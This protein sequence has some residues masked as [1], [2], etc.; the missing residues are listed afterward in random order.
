[1][2]TEMTEWWQHGIVYQVYIRSFA[3]GNA[4]GQ[5]DLAGLRTRLDYLAE[6]GIDAVWI[7]PWYDSPMR[8]GGYDVA[9]YRK[10]APRFGTV[11]EATQFIAEAHERNIKV[12]ADLVPNHTSS[13]HAWFQEA[14]AA[15]P[16]SPA[17]DRYIFR[18]G[19]GPDGSEP[20]SNW[21]G[22]FG[23]PA[24]EQVADGEWYLHIFDTS[25][26]DL[27]WEHPEVRAEFE[28]IFRFWLDRGVDGFRIDVA[29]GLIKDLTFPDVERA[30]RILEADGFDTPEPIDHPFW[31]RDGVHEIIRTW[32]AIVDEYDD[33]MMVA[34]AWAHRKRLPLY[35]RPDEYHQSF[36]FDLLAAEWRAESFGSIISNSLDAANE[37]GATSTWVLSN[38]D[39]VRHATRYGL[40]DGVAW[41]E[42]IN[43]GPFDILDLELGTRRARAVALITLALPGSTYVYQ[44]EEL[45]LHEVWDLP[46]EVLDDPTWERSGHT[47]RGRDGT[48]VPI[49]WATNGPSF[50]FGDGDPWLPQPDWFGPVSAAAQ[51][52]DPSSMLALYRSAIALRSDHFATNRSLEMVDLGNDVL[53][54][55]RGNVL[56]VANMSS[57]PIALP[58]GSIVLA[59]G[60]LDGNTIPAD[61]SV[62]VEQS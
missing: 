33:R 60:E 31:D 26:P 32:R 40:P 43:T 52:D 46:D 15:G 7:N 21:Q 56:V 34:E 38:H 10:I 12:I 30:S 39:V 25:Q 55:T 61:T 4:D 57:E 42:W 58:E 50:G 24:W 2:S 3:D 5:G 35:L 17:R 1:M 54:F 8:D 59:S 28:D 18:P 22:V 9:D 44:G 11:D 47:A 29:H 45:G 62:W 14:L 19:K 49:P 36:N 23:G 20:P 27:N 16:G 48:R 53:A 37:I 51:H 6:L 13:D 41:R